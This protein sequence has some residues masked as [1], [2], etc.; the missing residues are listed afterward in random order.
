MSSNLASRIESAVIRHRQRQARIEKAPVRPLTAS[1]RDAIL[2]A[3]RYSEAE[4]RHA[5]VMRATYERDK[6][7]AAPPPDDRKQLA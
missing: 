5:V 4:L 3:A 2:L 1:D 6:L 7:A